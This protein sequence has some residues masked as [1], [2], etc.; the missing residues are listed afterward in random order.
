M[1]FG[2]I[3]RMVKFDR[4]PINR[5]PNSNFA[6]KWTS[7]SSFY[8]DSTT[9]KLLL[10][11]FE[12]RFLGLPLFLS[13]CRLKPT[14]KL[15]LGYGD[16]YFLPI[17]GGSRCLCRIAWTVTKLYCIQSSSLTISLIQIPHSSRDVVKK[18][19]DVKVLEMV[20]GE[21]WLPPPTKVIFTKIISLISKSPL[22]I[23]AI[24]SLR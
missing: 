1:F 20:G 18:D 22:K 9:P 14:K 23:S 6:S 7:S 13:N 8:G 10:N 17:Y 4:R 21:D 16:E 3:I 24:T 12:T 19:E 2:L 5:N 11:L 15:R